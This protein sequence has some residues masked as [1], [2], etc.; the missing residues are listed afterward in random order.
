MNKAAFLAMFRR[1]SLVGLF[2]RWIIRTFKLYGLPLSFLVGYDALP[3]SHYAF[4][5]FHA[6]D[7]ARR[8]GYKCI[9]VMEFGVAGGNGLVAAEKII[10]LVEKHF[11]IEIE[12]YGFDTGAGLP[13]IESVY[14]IPYWFQPTQY[15]MNQMELQKR[16]KKAKLIIGNVADTVKGFLEETFAP[17]GVIFWDLDLY[18]ST[19]DGLNILK[20]KDG[21]K[22]LPRIFM[23]L[24]DVAGGVLEQYGEWNGELLA[25]KEFNDENDK[26]K[27]FR[28]EHLTYDREYA[29]LI[30]YAHHFWH[31]DFRKYIGG[32]NQAD[33]QASAKLK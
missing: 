14:D 3:R 31:P 29:R 11:S 17:I 16:L 26:V 33:V 20:S 21:S 12:L 1:Q 22:Y 28:N 30:F 2:I 23:Y 25:I 6:A 15:T 9:S 13:V 5:I 8:L 10:A 32:S 18:S 24:D 27:I 7:L 4:C 19:R